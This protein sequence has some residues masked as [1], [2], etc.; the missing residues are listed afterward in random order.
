MV[1]KNKAAKSATNAQNLEN[2][3]LISGPAAGPLISGS[4][5]QNKEITFPEY[6]KKIEAESANYS[7]LY[8]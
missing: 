4:L 1:D 3:S 5:P 2:T 6:D 7:K 8:S